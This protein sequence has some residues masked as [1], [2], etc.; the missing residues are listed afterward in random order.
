M[1]P[2][3]MTPE[4]KAFVQ[5]TVAQTIASMEMAR[6]EKS[7]RAK[8]ETPPTSTTT[9]KKEAVKEAL[10]PDTPVSFWVRGRRIDATV[11]EHK[12]A[13]YV[14]KNDQGTIYNIRRQ[15]IETFQDATAVATTV[16]TSSAVPT[17][18][19]F[20]DHEKLV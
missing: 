10:K 5:E 13:W 3:N 1:N 9:K 17:T 7:K 12:F 6:L 4:M 20:M 14:C 15:D 2:M 18:C 8:K 11:V 19:N 16:R